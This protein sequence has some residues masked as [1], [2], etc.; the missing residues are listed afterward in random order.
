MSYRDE[1]KLNIELP[2]H[3]DGIPIIR[4]VSTRARSLGLLIDY[5][6]TQGFYGRR[7]SWDL[8]PALHLPAE[9][10]IGR[11]PRLHDSTELKTL[12]P[13]PP[14]KGLVHLIISTKQKR[15]ESQPVERPEFAPVALADVRIER[16]E[17]VTYLYNAAETH[18]A[19]LVQGTPGSGKSSLVYQLKQYIHEHD[20]GACV[21]ITGSWKKHRARIDRIEGVTETLQKSI[22]ASKITGDTVNFDFEGPQK[23]WILL[24]EA[25]SAY[26]DETARRHFVFVLFAS[27]GIVQAT[28][29]FPKVI[30]GT[31]YQFNCTRIMGLRPTMNRLGGSEISG[32]YFTKEEYRRLLQMQQDLTP[33]LSSDLQ[34]WIFEITSGHIGVIHGLM[35]AVSQASKKNGQRLTNMS[36][37]TFLGSFDGPEDMFLECLR[38]PAST[39][40]IPQAQAIADPANAAIVEFCKQLLAADGPKRYTDENPPAE[41]E[42]AHQRWNCEGHLI[43]QPSDVASEPLKRAGAADGGEGGGQVKGNAN[44]IARKGKTAGP[45]KAVEEDAPEEEVIVEEETAEEEIVEEEA[46]VSEKS[47]KMTKKG[48]A[49]PAKIANSTKKSTAGAKAKP[50]IAGDEGQ[51]DETDGAYKAGSKRKRATKKKTVEDG[52]PVK[53][54]KKGVVAVEGVVAE[55]RPHRVRA[56]TR[57]QVA[58]VSPPVKKTAAGKG[59]APGRK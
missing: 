33:K 35:M 30:R 19:F 54:I 43:A 12:F 59:K 51:E 22:N 2:V 47:K 21:T 31:P 49:K 39:C 14:S 10:S 9:G 16:H 37:E 52:P 24:D 44:A 53:K 32:L 6:V 42:H 38:D 25:Q 3:D 26:F 34:N 13:S 5:I 45:K 36:L 58:P 1:L 41:A 18:G 56:S 11:G 57:A 27:H 8:E 29:Y 50:V 48:K 28:P 55:G 20:P 46:D 17:L 7:V 4:T 40:G 15:E 23:H